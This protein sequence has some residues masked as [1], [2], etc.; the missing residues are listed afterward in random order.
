MLGDRC[1]DLDVKYWTPTIVIVLLVS[2]LPG[3][4]HLR[5]PT[6]EQRQVALT[7][8]LPGIE[9]RSH[10]NVNIAKGLRRGGVQGAIEIYDWTTRAG[11]LGWFLHLADYRRNRIE[12]I[13]L[14][15]MIVRYHKTCPGSPVFL[16]AHSG[17]AGIAL[18]AVERLPQNV[19][20]E[21][22]ILLGGA[23]SPELDISKALARTGRGI[24]NFYSK[25]DLAFLVLGT[26]VFGTIDRKYGPSAGATGFEI[27]ADLS[28]EAG[29]LYSSKLHQ[30][31]YNGEMAYDGHRGGHQ[32]WA[33]PSFVARWVAPVIR[34]SEMPTGPTISADAPPADE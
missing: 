30:V 31:P 28:D 17:G 14:A 8:V 19:S 4:A 21:A 18:M 24:W 3:C 25:H 34:N 29:D 26:S 32:G 33:E 16:V 15:R 12:A 13:R 23:V 11:L 5:R 9:G 10:Y 22:V 1:Y 20:V 6:L 7:Y 2:I 27:P